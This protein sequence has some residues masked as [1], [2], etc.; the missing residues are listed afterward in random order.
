MHPSLYQLSRDNP[1][2]DV[3]QIIF[4]GGVGMI[5]IVFTQYSIGTGICLD[6]DETG[7]PALEPLTFDLPIPCG[8][9]HVTA[10]P[11]SSVARATVC[12]AF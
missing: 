8:L 1:D 6:L 2:P 10:F 7:A 12:L 9:L 3:L 5:M 4:A 11:T